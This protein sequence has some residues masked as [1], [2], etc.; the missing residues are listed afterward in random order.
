QV[1][2]EHVRRLDDMVI[3]ADQN[4][5]LFAHGN[6]LSVRP[7]KLSVLLLVQRY[8]TGPA[9]CAEQLGDCSTLPRAITLKIL[10]MLCAGPTTRCWRGSLPPRPR[11]FPNRAP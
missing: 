5:V 7:V 8:R 3:D 9:V 11:G 1:I 6:L 4:H 2:L 10:S